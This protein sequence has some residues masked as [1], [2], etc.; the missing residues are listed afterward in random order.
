M[1][2]TAIQK[3]KNPQ[4]P[5]NA[6]QNRQTVRPYVD[7]IEQ[8]HEYQIIADM[9]GTCQSDIDINF[10]R[11]ELTVHG[12]VKKACACDSS[13]TLKH[14]HFVPEDYFRMFHVGDHIQSD[15]ISADY[16]LGVLTLHLPKKEVAKPQK[17]SVSNKK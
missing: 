16:E 13:C 15:K 7:I 9:P 1:T 12:V 5:E 4:V 2:N 3:K 14:Q 8:D 10:N 6:T 17:I 11:G